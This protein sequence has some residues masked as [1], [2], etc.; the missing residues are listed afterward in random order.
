MAKILL[1]DDTPD[2]SLYLAK[3]LQ[4]LGHAVDAAADGTEGFAK[5]NSG[6]WDIII[7]DLKLPGEPSGMELVRKI[8]SVRP[9]TALIVVS[10]FPTPEIIRE[11]DTL[12][13]KDFLTKPFEVSFIRSVVERLMAEKTQTGA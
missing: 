5:A 1:I 8:R 4:R 13:V 3:L 10:G 2:V 11:C 12:G 9:D 7:S 6:E